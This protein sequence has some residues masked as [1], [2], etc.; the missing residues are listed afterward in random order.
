MRGLPTSVAVVA[1]ALLGSCSYVKNRA[2]DLLDP[3]R[4][5]VGFTPGLYAE[6]RA[7]DFAALGLGVRG[8][9]IVGLH[10]RFA[11]QHDTVNLGVGPVMLGDVIQPEASALLGGESS[12]DR[13]H[14][15]VPCQMFFIPLLGSEHA[16]DWSLARRSVHVADVGASVAVG[17]VGAGVGFSPGEFVDLLLGFVEI[18]LAGDDDFGGEQASGRTASERKRASK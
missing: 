3:F 13:H 7:T 11:V 4:L 5:D 17:L 1:S 9:T 16:P 2:N 12:Y 8:G 6:A 10:G 14:D 15:A 18:D